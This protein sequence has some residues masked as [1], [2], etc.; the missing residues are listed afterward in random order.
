[1]H[2]ALTAWHL[3]PNSH[4]L[5][6]RPGGLSEYRVEDGRVEDLGDTAKVG[7]GE[8]LARAVLHLL[9]LLLVT[10]GI[11]LVYWNERRPLPSLLVLLLF[12][13]SGLLP[14]L[15]RRYGCWLPSLLALAGFAVGAHLGE[16]AHI[17]AVAAPPGAE[18]LLLSTNLVTVPQGF[19]EVRKTL[20]SQLTG[21]PRRLKLYQYSWSWGTALLVVDAGKV[22]EVEV[23]SQTVQ[24]RLGLETMKGRL[25]PEA[26]AHLRKLVSVP[27]ISCD[28]GEQWWFPTATGMLKIS[29]AYGFRL[30]G[31]AVYEGDHQLFRLGDE[32]DS[33]SLDRFKY[34]HPIG[35]VCK[36]E[37]AEPVIIRIDSQGRV[38][39]IGNSDFSSWE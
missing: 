5:A 37:G 15:R 16:M 6:D 22:V 9:P 20:Q 10:I 21:E 33:R 34:E 38:T 1:M 2:A 14:Y 4:V 12:P 26:D 30:D 25:Y 13:M 32:L 39:K 36:Q 31:S 8:K 35:Y 28:I 17:E 18:K 11:G 23:P 24:S 7:L 29:T 19:E 3:N 27:G